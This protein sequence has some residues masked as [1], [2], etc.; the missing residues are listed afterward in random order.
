LD[1]VKAR[2]RPIFMTAIIDIVG[3]L[4]AAMSE[5]IGSEAQ[6]PLATVM[7]GGFI[8]SELLVIFILPILYF[9]FY[10]PKHLREHKK[11]MAL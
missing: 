8:A 7:I 11:M 10:Y 4:P 2:L 1:G 5:G 9:M 6:K 3:L